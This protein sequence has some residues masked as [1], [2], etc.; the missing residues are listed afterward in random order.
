MVILAERTSRGRFQRSFFSNGEKCFCTILHTNATEAILIYKFHMTVCGRV[1]AAVTLESKWNA[2]TAIKQNQ[3]GYKQMILRPKLIPS[4]KNYMPSTSFFQNL[5]RICV[6]FV[7]STFLLSC[8]GI[9]YQLGQT[10]SSF[11]TVF[12]MLLHY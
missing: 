11:M 3:S 2:N 6:H 1:L 12:W 5:N 7:F 4:N 8:K 9:W 10:H